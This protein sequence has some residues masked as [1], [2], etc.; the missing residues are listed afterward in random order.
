[1][2][3]RSQSQAEAVVRVAELMAVFSLAADLGSGNA[4][5]HGLRSTLV[6]LEL[7]AALGLGHEDTRDLYDLSLLRMIGCT[8]DSHLSAQAL[9]DEILVGRESARL[10]MGNHREAIEWLFRE[11]GRDLPIQQRAALILKL[12][13][14]TPKKRTE[15]LAAHCEVAGMLASELGRK[16][17]V[18]TALGQVFERWEGRGAPSGLRGEAIDVLARIV[19]VAVDVAIFAAVGGIEE[20]VA[21]CRHRAG[22]LHY[23][24]LVDV[25]FRTS[26]TIAERLSSAD[27][28]AQVLAAEPPPCQILEAQALDRAC[29]AMGEFA[30]MKSVFTAG[31]SSRVAATA[32]AAGRRL[33]LSADILNRLRRAALVHDLG[34]VAVSTAIWD[35]PGRLSLLQQDQVRLFPLHGERIL[36]R[37]STLRPEAA[38]VGLQREALDGSGYPRGFESA[39]I[40]L[41]AR[42]LGTASAYVAMREPRAW[43]PPF[44][45]AAAAAELQAEARASRMDTKVVDEVAHGDAPRPRGRPRIEALSDRE[46]EVLGLLAAGGTNHEIGR[47]LSI[48]ART[49]EHHIRSVYDKLGVRS[50]AAATLWAARAG[51]APMDE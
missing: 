29:A 4:E 18:V 13:T 17:R 8:A 24:C 44:S 30:D 40:P 19:S 37:A 46:T 23:P 25:L 1:M 43:R 28:L 49:V 5:E 35:R 45:H 50:R 42:L 10:D 2:P 27:P 47:R 14:Y 34:R 3:L 6:A 7:G 20:A 41:E 21:V 15:Q 38:L 31:R 9:G 32:V 12:M 26:G 36:S 39:A 48:S 11:F 16:P 22:G 51:L 33:G